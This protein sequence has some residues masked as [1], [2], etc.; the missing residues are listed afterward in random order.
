[1]SDYPDTGDRVRVLPRA[2]EPEHRRGARPE[3]VGQEG[4]IIHN[5]GY[6]FCAVEFDDGTRAALWNGCDLEL[7]T[8][9]GWVSPS[10]GVE[11]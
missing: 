3:L 4:R 11:S 10:L 7:V 8:G 1:M 9:K 2:A 6:G 5:D